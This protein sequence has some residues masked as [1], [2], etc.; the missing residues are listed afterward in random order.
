MVISWPLNMPFQISDTGKKILFSSDTLYRKRL[1]S[2]RSAALGGR[3]KSPDEPVVV[4]K[5]HGAEWCP[6]VP[7]RGRGRAMALCQDSCCSQTALIAHHHTLNHPSPPISPSCQ[8]QKRT[9]PLF[10]CVQRHFF[11]PLWTLYLWWGIYSC[12]LKAKKKKKRDQLLV[13]TFS[14]V[15][16]HPCVCDYFMFFCHYTWS[17]EYNTYSL[18]SWVS[19]RPSGLCIRCMLA[20]GGTCLA[21]G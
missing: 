10:F 13:Y 11:F 1:I 21:T 19:K 15:Q 8:A 17:S 5:M 2:I 9:K 6:T 7:R 18:Y 3:D 14:C 12:R 20:S 4:V 16:C